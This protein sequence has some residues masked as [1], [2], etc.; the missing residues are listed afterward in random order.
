[1]LFLDG[2][3]KSFS[4]CVVRG[5]LEFISYGEMWLCSALCV[6]VSAGGHLAP[7]AF[8]LQILLSAVLL[9]VSRRAS[10][11]CDCEMSGRSSPGRVGVGAPPLPLG[12]RPIMV[13]DSLASWGSCG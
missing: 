11:S 13:P 1:M 2:W 8:V 4:S 7:P 5:V 6:W 10:C 3:G 12:K 9:C